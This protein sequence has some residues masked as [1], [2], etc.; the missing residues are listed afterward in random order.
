MKVVHAE[1]QSSVV[2]PVTEILGSPTLNATK[3]PGIKMRWEPGDGLYI[4]TG[5]LALHYKGGI[6][7][8]PAANVKCCIG[9]L[10]EADGLPTKKIKAV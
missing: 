7:F 6:G 10:D 9:V 8:I 1:L 2:F 3:V 4:E 5:K